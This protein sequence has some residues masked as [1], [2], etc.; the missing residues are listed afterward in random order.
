MKYRKTTDATVPRTTS[1]PPV[2]NSK[3]ALGGDDTGA[4]DETDDKPTKPDDDSHQNIIYIVIGIVAVAVPLGIA[5]FVKVFFCSKPVDKMAAPAPAPVHFT[6]GSGDA[7]ITFDNP[8]YDI[9][10]SAPG[11]HPMKE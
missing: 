10:P 3:G 9:T 6:Q 2:M 1:V 5:A 8:H 7:T 11:Y 4:G